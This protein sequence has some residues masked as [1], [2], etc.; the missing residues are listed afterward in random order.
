MIAQLRDFDLAEDALADATARAAEKWPIEGIPKNGG[1]WLLTVARRAAIDRIRRKKTRTSEASQATITLLAESDEMAEDAHEIPDERL[2]LIFT[3]CHPALAQEAQVA[4]TLK[5]LCGLT[6]REIARAFLVS[7]PTMNQRLTRAKSKIAKTGIAYEIPEGAALPDR[8][9]QVL[10]VIYLIY[11]ESYSAFEGQSLTRA[12]LAN[13]AL[14]LARLLARLLPDPETLGLQA[15]LCLHD[16][17]RPARLGTKGE[18]IA[19]ENQD[20]AA[21]DQN[22]ITEGKTT[23]IRALS[24]RHPGFYQIQAAISA[25]H[26]EAPS[27]DA[28]DWPQ[29]AGLYNA[30]N[31][32]APSPVVQLNRAV[33]LGNSGD[34]GAALSILIALEPDLADY[35]PYFAARADIHRQLGNNPEAFSDYD[36]AIDLSRNETERRFLSSQKSRLRNQNK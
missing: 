21:W 10:S 14:R 7:E 24:A 17:R 23:L 32:L 12:D 34:R 30:L 33:A 11:N 27:W 19:L 25:L 6:A 26:C 18:M 1:A 13:E 2:R 15:L 4:L 16:A 35:Q 22:L 9:P 20:R 36:R 28:T 8:L 31:K 5:T 3:C 29:I